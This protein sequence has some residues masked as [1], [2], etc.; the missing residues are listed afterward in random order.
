MA[1]MTTHSTIGE[2][3]PKSKDW[4]SYTEWLQQ[5]FITNDVEDTEKKCAIFLGVC[6]AATYKLI[7]SFVNPHQEPIWSCKLNVLSSMPDG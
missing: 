4:M 6:G 2:F 1:K 3:D 7:H 5:Y